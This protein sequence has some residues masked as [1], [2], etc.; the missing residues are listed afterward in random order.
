M[1]FVH[2]RASVSTLLL[3][4]LGLVALCP[5]LHFVPK[6]RLTLFEL[7]A[8]RRN[9]DARTAFY[10]ILLEAASIIERIFWWRRFFSL[11]TEWLITQSFSFPDLDHAIFF[12][13]IYA[14][15]IKRTHSHA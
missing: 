11:I 15:S 1:R 14:L 2:A 3:Y 10:F 8:Q 9:I 4:A 6:A 13:F 12:V 7:V 5:P